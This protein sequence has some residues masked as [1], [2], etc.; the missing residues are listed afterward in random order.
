[1]MEMK[2]SYIAPVNKSVE[3]G[4]SSAILSQS[5]VKSGTL[6]LNKNPWDEEEI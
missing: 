4:F 5:A 6:Q 1:M 3:I 2:K